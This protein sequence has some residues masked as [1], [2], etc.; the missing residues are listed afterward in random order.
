MTDY[1][2]ATVVQ[3]MPDPSLNGRTISEIN[4]LA[5]RESTVDNEI[6]TILDMMIDG[7]AAGYIYGASMIYHYM[8]VEDV[9][10][11][12]RYPNAA[13][14]SDGNINAFGRGQPHPRSYGTNARVLG[15]FVR[16]RQVLTLE[17]A[18]RKMTSL[19][20]RTFGF[21][22]RGIVR[23]GFVADLVLFDPERVADKATFGSPHQY[24]VGFDYV[25]V[26]GIAVVAGGELT[27]R[28]P[29]EFVAGT[30]SPVPENS[31][32]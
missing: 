22:D 23:P 2:F 12:F 13:V 30:G 11:I 21:H 17:E 26:N 28:R 18:V 19:P 16:D 7:G 25:F 10:T 20:A 1:S 24:S 5:E 4:R 8:S 27:D 6:A 15:D 31:D 3:Y 9:D 32:D 14:A 29:G